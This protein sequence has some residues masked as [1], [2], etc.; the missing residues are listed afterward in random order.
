MKKSTSSSSGIAEPY[1]RDKKIKPKNRGG[2]ERDDTCDH[3]VSGS[4]KIKVSVKN[5]KKKKPR[6]PSGAY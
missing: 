3:G 2:E 5:N 1:M 4:W 6:I